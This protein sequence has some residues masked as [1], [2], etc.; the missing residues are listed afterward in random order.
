MRPVVYIH[1]NDQQLVAARLCAYSLKARSRHADAFDVRL[2]RLEETPHL[3]PAREGRRYICDGRVCRWHN[4]DLQAFAPLR[5]MVPQAMGFQGKALVLDPDVFAVGDVYE[6]LARDLGGK[7]LLC[8][9][10]AGWYRGKPA[11]TYSSAVM[12]M[13][14]SRL[15]HWRWNDDIDALF[16]R[17]L[18]FATWL[19][20]YEEPPET[21][22]IL[23]DEWNHL[24][25]LNERTRLLHNT[26]RLTQPWKT[27]L[28]VDFDLDA[29]GAYPHRPGFRPRAIVS[30]LKRRLSPPPPRAGPQTYQP[31]PNPRQERFF[32]RLLREA[33]EHGAIT[34]T[35]LVE[36]IRKQHL[37]A[38]VFDG[39][40]RASLH[41]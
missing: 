8:R 17:R 19:W 3:Y 34:E 28:P 9:K 2:L 26:E 15:T 38:D 41:R 23:E 18:D 1:T 5:K 33:L 14:C 13:D 25:T 32:F 4:R 20:L 7:A 39:L 11:Q 27:G 12:L 22:G 29:E 30:R 40:E 37:R 21:I 36:E 6:L 24:D 35:F 31:H 16:S 10:R